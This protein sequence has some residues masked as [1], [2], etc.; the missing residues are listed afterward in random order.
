[1]YDDQS[2]FTAAKKTQT[3]RPILLIH[4][5]ADDNVY[6]SNSLRLTEALQAAKVPVEFL[7]LTDQTHLVRSPE[8]NMVVWRRVAE[9]LLFHLAKPEG[10]AID[11]LNPYIGPAPKP[12]PAPSSVPASSAKP[13]S[14]L[15]LAPTRL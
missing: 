12:A 2:L 7:P 6:F 3:P 1:V 15:Q 5:T 9:F 8:A 13:A 11:D 4:G 10:H 14:S